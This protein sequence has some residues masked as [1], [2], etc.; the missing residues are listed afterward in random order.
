MNNTFPRTASINDLW[1]SEHHTL[2]QEI[3]S[4]KECQIGILKWA[5]NIL[6]AVLAFSWGLVLVRGE[7]V[8]DAILNTGQ[9]LP[10]A[11]VLLI[12]T[13]IGSFLVQILIH[14]TRSVFRLCGYI[15]ILEKLL[16]L[17]EPPENNYPGYENTYHTLRMI[18]QEKGHVFDINFCEAC[19]LFVK[20]IRERCTSFFHKVFQIK[21]TT[22]DQPHPSSG[23]YYRM[24]AFQI[25]LLC[26]LSLASAIFLL[27]KAD[28]MLTLK[29]AI[30]IISILIW[31]HSY[32]RSIAQT[33]L[34]EKEEHSINGQYELWCEALD[35]LGCHVAP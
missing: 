30:S 16:I 28:I 14:K 21:N 18:Q 15:R 2:R 23:K 33:H 3:M 8:T 27:F 31:I 24:V 25:H 1:Q 9:A 13:I 35:R 26:I 5:Y 17:R 34:Q 7:M 11:I 19:R 32:I 6:G 4:L 22:A 12:G 20:D 10:A 29:I